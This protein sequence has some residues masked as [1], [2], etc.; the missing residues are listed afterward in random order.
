MEKETT[1]EDV[2]LTKDFDLGIDF[3]EDGNMTPTN[4]KKRKME[5]DFSSPYKVK[6]ESKGYLGDK[7]EKA[8]LKDFE[9]TTTTNTYK[10]SKGGRRTKKHRRSNKRR[11]KKSRKNRKTRRR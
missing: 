5:I 10:K 6:P 11:S 8:L 2:D 4:T 3:D 1:Y 9:I 7:N